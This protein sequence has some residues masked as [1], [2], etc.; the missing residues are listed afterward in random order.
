MCNDPFNI[1]F[2]EKQ[3]LKSFNMAIPNKEYVDGRIAKVEGCTTLDEFLDDVFPNRLD[4]VSTSN[5]LKRE[6]L[7]K[8]ML[9]YKSGSLEK[10]MKS[11]N[12]KEM[13][14]DIYKPSWDDDTQLFQRLRVSGIKWIEDFCNKPNDQVG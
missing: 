9:Q 13:M 5:P 4:S 7:R 3:T 8:W 12:P 10:S 11:R 1:T 2:F 14:E 6:F